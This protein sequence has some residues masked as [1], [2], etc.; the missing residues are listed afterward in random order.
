M[1]LDMATSGD[2][3]ARLDYFR[4][5]ANLRTDFDTAHVFF[6]RHAARPSLVF[7]AAKWMACDVDEWVP[8]EAEWPTRGLTVAAVLEALPKLTQPADRVEAALWLVNE[9]LPFG[10]AV[11]PVWDK[12]VPDLR[13]LA[14]CDDPRQGH[15]VIARTAHRVFGLADANVKRVMIRAVSDSLDRLAASDPV[16]AL[17]VALDLLS[18]TA[19]NEVLMRTTLD[20]VAVV[21]LTDLSRTAT[22]E[23]A[24][25]AAVQLYPQ[26]TKKEVVA[27]LLRHNLFALTREQPFAGMW[28]AEQLFKSD[29]HAGL[30]REAIKAGVMGMARLL[31]EEASLDGA[32]AWVTGAMAADTH[33]R[34]VGLA[35]LAGTLQDMTQGIPV[36]G[37]QGGARLYRMAAEAPLKLRPELRNLAVSSVVWGCEGLTESGHEGKALGAG[38]TWLAK[39]CGRPMGRGAVDAFRD[40]LKR[41][42]SGSVAA[43]FSGG[44]LADSIVTEEL[45]RRLRDTG[46]GTTPCIAFEEILACGSLPLVARTIGRTPT[47]RQATYRRV[48]GHT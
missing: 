3:E 14:D 34:E 7:E 39:H 5:R 44:R 38:L 12:V 4:T 43:V 31:P 30:R 41:A 16:R 46:N 35:A 27:G 25:A 37:V 19:P 13:S 24:L 15:D 33:F 28:E 48:F 47:Q 6:E 10:R 36:H 18:R 22:R 26:T 17:E 11:T 23:A 29:K 2:V 9:Q 32:F 42:G 45:R 21:G 1:V 40:V 8:D 20:T